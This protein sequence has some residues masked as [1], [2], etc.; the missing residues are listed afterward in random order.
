VIWLQRRYWVVS[1]LFLVGCA[2]A[3]ASGPFVVHGPPEHVEVPEAVETY[4]T[5]AAP[6]GVVGGPGGE[7]L[8]AD[9]AAEL[10]KRGTPAVADGALA[11]AA[12]WVLRDLNEGRGISQSSGEAAAR[13]FGFTGVIESMVGFSLDAE[14]GEAWRDALARVPENLPITRFGVSVSASGRTAV[15]MLGAVEI[16]LEPVARHVALGGSLTLRGEVA[17]RFGFAH[18]YITKPD[19]SVE[20]RRTPTRK[21]EAAI[22]FATP[23]KYNVEVMGDGPSGPVIVF[24]VPVYVGVEEEQFHSSAGHVTDPAQAEAR[25]LELLN[26][27]RKAAGF[28]A[29][30]VDEELRAIALAHST[31]MAEHNFFGHVSPTTG[32]TEDRGHR[33]GVV[34]A[35]LGENIAQADSAENAFDGLMASPGHRSAM[36]NP[37][38]THVGIAVVRAATE[39]AF[40]LIF[41]RR[42]PASAVPR[43]A[44]QVEA[45]LLALRANQGLPRAAPDA[46]YAAAADAGAAA[47]VAASKPTPEIAAKAEDEALAREVERTRSS[48]AGGCSFLTEIVELSQL[49]GTPIL[50]TPS[51]KRFGVGAR[52]HT[53]EHGSRLAVMMVLEGVPCR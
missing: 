20:Q 4:S 34:V 45:A 27:A 7:R 35:A 28:N 47:Y 1:F 29:L 36:L 25:M 42:V 3:G 48:R 16:S 40:T 18:I 33:A 15:V 12:T 38:Y 37:Q 23:G 53:D 52:M 5:A 51:L 19:G 11:A 10:V 39:L 41:A 26:D 17:S 8:A 2:G 31:D 6:N 24:N 22:A 46:L 49:E 32:T 30:L 14:N 13:A 43:S 9:I 21:L 50:M 44:S